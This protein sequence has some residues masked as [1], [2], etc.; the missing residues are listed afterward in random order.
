[1]SIRYEQATDVLP[2]IPSRFGFRQA[3]EIA[4]FTPSDDP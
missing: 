2:R 3:S 4:W 1:M